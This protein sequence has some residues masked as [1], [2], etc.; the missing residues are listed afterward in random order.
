VPIADPAFWLLAAIVAFAFAVEAATGFG[1]TVI[2][3]AL[4][5]HLFPLDVL[6]PVLVPLGLVLSVTIAWRERAHLDRALLLRRILPLM[7]AGLL[8]GILLF[9]SASNA[10]LRRAF[11]AFVVAVSALELWRARTTAGAVPAPLAPAAEGA[12][13]LG[14]GVVHGLFSTGG[15]LLV[16]ALGRT[17]IPKRTF[18]A[19]LSTVWVVMGTA[20]SV[21][22]AVGGHLRPVTLAATATLLPVLGVALLAGDWLHHRLHEAHFRTLVYALLLAAGV[23]NLL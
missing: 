17:A 22:Y 3:V 19:T 2:A 7:G 15:P 11:G 20:L 12:A 6:L 16:Y 13:L 5:V 18:R 14:A 4:G 8:A 9:E 23:T 21:A 10:S 1:A